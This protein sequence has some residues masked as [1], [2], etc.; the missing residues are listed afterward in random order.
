MSSIPKVRVPQY[1]PTPGW[2]PRAHVVQIYTDD[3]FLLECLTAFI[4]DALAAG[5]SAISVLSPQHLDG[6]SHR[7]RA[8]T[9]D[10]DAALKSN[11]Y[12]EMDAAEGLAKLMASKLPDRRSFISLVGSLIRKAE[13]ASDVKNKRVAVVGEMVAL[14]LASGNLEAT[15]QLEQLWN[16]LAA[17]HF[18][19]LRCVY[20]SIGFHGQLK[21]EPYA[22]ICAEHSV[23]IPAEG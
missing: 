18:F 22:T 4:G 17:T 10:V 14:S 1:S 5:E 12:I 3:D 9:I 7:L 16:E 21:G 6:L 23:V 2:A 19:H 13:V 8:R 11:R 15:V 20:P